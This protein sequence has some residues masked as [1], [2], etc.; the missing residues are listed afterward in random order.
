[1]HIKKVGITIT[2]IFLALVLCLSTYVTAP[3]QKAY[4]AGVTPPT[5]TIAALPAGGGQPFDPSAGTPFLTMGYVQDE[6]QMSGT[7][8][9]Y[10]NTSPDGFGIQIRTAGVAYVTRIL[11]RRPANAAAFS[12]NVFVEMLNPSATYDLATGWQTQWSQLINDGDIWVGV[13]CRQ[14]IIDSGA[15]LHTGLKKFDPVRYANLTF[16]GHER[17]LCWDVF[18]QLGYMLK[19][20]AATIPTLTGYTVNRVIAHGYSQTGAMLITFINFFDQYFVPIFDGYNP[21]AAGGPVWMNDDDIATMV[22]F[23]GNPPDDARRFIRQ[24]IGKPIIHIVTESEINLQAASPFLGA[25]ITRQ[26]D[27]DANLFRHYEIAGGCHINLGGYQTFPPAAHIQGALGFPAEWCCSEPIG[28]ISDYHQE[29]IFHGAYVNLKA[30]I[31]NHAT[32]PPKAAAYITTGAAPTYTIARDA[33]GNALGGVRSPWLDIP[34]K[35]YSPAMTPCPTCGLTCGA[36]SAFCPL[37]GKMASLSCSK[38]T[39]L[40]A[41]AAAYSTA[42]NTSVDTLVAAK[43]F[44]ANDTA[45][46]KAEKDNISGCYGTNSGTVTTSLGTVRFTVSAGN[47]TT[48]TNSDPATSGCAP[49]GFGFPYG[50]FNFTI[51]GLTPGQSVKITI[52][53]PSQLPMGA[54]KYFKCINGALVD[55]TS[56]ISQPDPS[57]IIITITDG[58]LG[59][60]DGKVNGTITDPGGPAIPTNMSSAPAA[61]SSQVATVPLGPAAIANVSV[62]SA[63][64]SATAVAPGSPVTVTATVANT[65]TANGNAR[66]KL[67]VNGQEESSQG[68]SLASGSTS[69]VKFNVTRN[70]PGTYSVYVGGINAGTFTVDAMADPN[71]ILYISGAAIFFAFIL[72]VIYISRRRQR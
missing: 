45:T 24:D 65:G 37:F 27:S 43:W 66:I 8:N 26:A 13:T 3:P 5:P 53:L 69:P 44:V 50:F 14:V 49:S 30:W 62:K 63:S 11:I 9:V 2:Y 19:T 38:I 35:T 54:I 58:G 60:A 36:F 34:T 47:L 20:S 51:T 68:V 61:S 56:L 46:I 70:D 4:A 40:Y 7:A 55:V 52:N 57:I 42:F 1:M 12:G 71:I 22:G 41:N 32:L 31:L 48:L 39:G 23:N 10:E 17:E 59:D 33:N 29:A 28:T 16:N 18:A 6:Y 21:M 72:G 67:F 15:P 25:I 64:L